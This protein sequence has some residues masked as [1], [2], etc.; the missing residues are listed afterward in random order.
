M[1]IYGYVCVPYCICS[2]YVLVMCC[3]CVVYVLVMDW[4]I[5]GF[6]MSLLLVCYVLVMCWEC[7]GRIGYVMVI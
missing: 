2:G 1:V 5:V 3:S 7:V 6:G 4:L